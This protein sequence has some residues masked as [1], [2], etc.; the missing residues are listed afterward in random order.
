LPDDELRRLLH[1]R[2]FSRHNE[3][4]ITSNRRLLQEAD[5]IRGK[6]YAL[7]DEEDEVGF[8]C[9]GVPVLDENGSTVAAISVAGSVTQVT[10]E[11]MKR[12]V[13]VL[14]KT[15]ES[16]TTALSEDQPQE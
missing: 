6:G 15:A 4:T 8:R 5:E 1:G 9:I 3:N 14:K 13:S 7:D 11:N 16:I 2:V 10:N 12:L